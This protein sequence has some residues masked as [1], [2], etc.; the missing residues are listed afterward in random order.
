MEALVGAPGFPKYA[1]SYGGNNSPSWSSDSLKDMEPVRVGERF[2]EALGARPG[3][4][5]DEAAEH[6]IGL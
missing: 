5:G 2:C 4:E 1:L 3:E 6:E